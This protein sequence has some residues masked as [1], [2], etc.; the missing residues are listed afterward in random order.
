[1]SDATVLL[2]VA[3]GVAVITLN[4]P[5]KLNAFAGDMRERLVEALDRVAA[6][7]DVRVLVITGAGKASA[8]RRRSAHG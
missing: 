2:T 1:V 3:D 7:R 4:R 8:G 5:E 6:N